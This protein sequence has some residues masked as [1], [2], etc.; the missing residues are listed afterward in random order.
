M[1][2]TLWRKMRRVQTLVRQ[3]GVIRT[4]RRGVA[5][6]AKRAEPLAAH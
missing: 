3:E 1:V 4:A 2:P 5:S 6:P